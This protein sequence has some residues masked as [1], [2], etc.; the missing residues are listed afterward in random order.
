MRQAIRN[1][2]EVITMDPYYI[3]E[4]GCK[5][6]GQDLMMVFKTPTPVELDTVFEC[7][8]IDAEQAEDKNCKMPE[9]YQAYRCKGCGLIYGL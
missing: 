2:L 7:I 3:V 6:C 1:R 5:V 8:F 9:M 4:K